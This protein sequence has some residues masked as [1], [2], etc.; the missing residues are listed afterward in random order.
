MVAAVMSLVLV[1]AAAHADPAPPA[2]KGPC[3]STCDDQPTTVVAEGP[4]FGI[5]QHRKPSDHVPGRGT[6]AKHDVDGKQVWTT[7]EEYI[8][9]ICSMN[10]LHGADAMCMAAATYCQDGRVGF[11]VW[12]QVT[13]HTRDAQGNETTEVGSW[14]QEEGAFCLGADDPG[15]PTIG[16]VIS[17]VQDLFLNNDVGILPLAVRAEP[18]PKTLV[19][20]PTRFSGGTGDVVDIPVATP[21][22]N[23]VIHA[24]PLRWRWTF[25]DGTPTVVTTVP[26][27]EH[28]YLHPGVL[29][30]VHVDVEWGGTFSVVGDP[31]AYPVVGTAMVPGTDITVDV[32]EA[33]SELVSH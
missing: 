6:V 33:R 29:T 19:N 24:K 11:W 4:K 16:K 22:A 28:T 20:M 15:V 26:T 9:P 21:W 14:I 31:T 3:F 5:T 27:V 2:P 8:T 23:V 30:T 18:A 7:T 25:G 12:H 32:R 13:T 10:G 17:R 1:S